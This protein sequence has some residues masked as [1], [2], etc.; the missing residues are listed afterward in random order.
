MNQLAAQR[1][2]I[3]EIRELQEALAR[4]REEKATLEVKLVPLK[5]SAAKDKQATSKKE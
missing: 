4:G 2:M 1:E 5:A 3:Q